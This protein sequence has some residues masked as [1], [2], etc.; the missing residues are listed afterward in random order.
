[1]NSRTGRLEELVDCLPDPIQRLEVVNA[2]HDQVDA[3]PE[4]WL[5]KLAE[6]HLVHCHHLQEK[7]IYAIYSTIIRYGFDELERPCVNFI[8]YEFLQP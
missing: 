5:I 2:L 7:D 3:G 8:S 1:M 4:P 6:K